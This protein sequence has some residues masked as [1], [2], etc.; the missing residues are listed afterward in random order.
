MKGRQWFYLTMRFFIRRALSIY[1]REIRVSSRSWL[2]RTGPLLLASNH[3]DSFLD[4]IIIGSRFSKPVYFLARG[5]AFRRPI[6]RKI[7]TALK[8][9][10]IYRLSE[11]REHLALNDATFDRC[12]TIF[13]EE[14]IILI[15]SEGL[16][17]NQWELRPLKK[18]TAR[19]ALTALHSPG[20]A[21][22]LEI[23]PVSISYD[24]FR[25][26]GKKV[27]IDFGDP[28]PREEILASDREALNIHQFNEMLSSRLLTG[29]YGNRSRMYQR[30]K[31]FSDL[32]GLILLFPFA[33]AGFL[34]HA[35]LFLSLRAIA[36][37]RTAG[38]VFYDSVL[39]GLLLLCY[40]L[41]YGLLLLAGI[42]LITPYLFYFILAIPFLA[43]TYTK[44]KSFRLNVFYS[45]PAG[46]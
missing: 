28:L 1:C 39:F 13:Q 7:L 45:A 11:G 29:I 16:C 20:K 21:Q 10:P 35:P 14:G 4:A 2:T 6:V 37:K 3:P 23:L 33:L 22:H 43:L 31:K 18:G 46:L 36:R 32:A 5:D 41:Y 40:P 44:W 9:I 8:L 30:Q 19:I 42:F 34:I 12:N 15:F 26:F 38:T 24:S 25:R 27:L 17:V